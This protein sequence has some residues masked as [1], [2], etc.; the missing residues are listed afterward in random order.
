MT[1]RPILLFD[2]VC[3]LC[4][5]FVQFIIRQDKKEQFLFAALQSEQG[6]ALLRQYAPELTDLKTVVMIH[7]EQV[8]F[9]SDA[10][11]EIGRLLGG[12]WRL[13]YIFKLVPRFIRDSIYNTI[14]SNRYKWFGQQ[15]QC[16]LPTPK[17]RNR[18][19]DNVSIQ[20]I[21]E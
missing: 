17:L 20:A 8:Y 5:G 1:D 10:A 21:G 2:G 12:L 18:F 6:Q 11:L 13:G 14:A 3:N 7:Q 9:R 16:M 4:N 19:L 15:E